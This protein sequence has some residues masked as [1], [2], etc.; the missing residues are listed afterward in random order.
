MK[1]VFSKKG[2]SCQTDETQEDLTQLQTQIDELRRDNNASQTGV[3]EIREDLTQLQVQIDELS[4][5]NN[6]L[7]IKI[8]EQEITS[9]VR[10]S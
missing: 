10:S 8:T 4:R 3:I 5:L 1:K 2:E 7:R 9:N 6:V